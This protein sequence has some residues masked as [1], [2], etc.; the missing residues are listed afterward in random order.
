[1]LLMSE[2]APAERLADDLRRCRLGEAAATEMVAR[3]ASRLAL[4]TASAIMRDRQD[5]ADVAQDVTLDVLRSLGT[6]REPGAFDG[7]VH[8]IAARH[9]LRAIRRRKAARA[10]EM[11]LALLA[12]ADEPTAPSGL[13]PEDLLTARAALARALSTLPPKQRVALVLR[14]VHDL[15]DAQIAQ[16]LGCRLGTAHALLSRGRAT[17]RE[18]PALHAYLQTEDATGGRR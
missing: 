13:P 16:A 1:M 9:A 8:R 7:W 15:S 3:R 5:A 14:Y 10:S 6:L 18:D 2:G 12:P 11:P 17:L 4:R